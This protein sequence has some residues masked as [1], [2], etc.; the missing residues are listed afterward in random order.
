MMTRTRWLGLLVGAMLL[1]P[2]AA[3]GQDY[4]VGAPSWE[5][6]IPTMWGDKDEG[7]YFAAEALFFR[8][9]N[10][11]RSQILAVRGFWD[12]SGDISGRGELVDALDA[13]GNVIQQLFSQNGPPGAFIGSKQAAL[14]SNEVGRDKFEPGFRI[15]GGYRFRNGIAVE[16]SI[17]YLN[18]VQNTAGAG[19][20]PPGSTGFA[21]PGV[22][23]NN[24]SSFL[25]A[26]FFNFTPDFAGPAQDVVSNIYPN[27]VI[28]GTGVPLSPA[29]IALI[30]QFG[31]IPV[32]AYGIWN[33]AEDM[34]LEFVQRAWN[35]EVNCRL[36]VNQTDC[37]RTYVIAGA[38][39][40]NIW[41]RFSFRTVDLDINSNPSPLNTATYYNTWENQL[42][43]A[44]V[45]MGY[46]YYIGQGFSWSVEGRVGLFLDYRKTQ[47]QVE[48]GDVDPF[49]ERDD[50]GLS[51]FFQGGAFVWWYPLEGVQMRAGYEF[52][53]IFNVRRSEQPVSFDLGKL[54]ATYK[55]MF[56]RFD[57]FS[58]GIAFIF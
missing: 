54:D 53:G 2:A 5:F 38:R 52:Q 3:R 57:G 24:A 8:I 36:P 11:V 43:G 35:A 4:N 45:G 21:G 40:M 51:P 6:P 56:L 49:T 16:G 18:E 19:I 44:Q 41:E 47:I 10:P 17:W 31:G 15:T 12:T 1:L 9:N 29:Q 58:A 34:T 23:R 25:S 50:V 28:N 20:V 26:P 39:V 22:G 14:S 37:D 32:A 46:E 7:Y 55:D 30:T 13:G 48:R 33:G 27:P 42:Y